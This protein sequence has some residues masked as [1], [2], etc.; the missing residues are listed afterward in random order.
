MAGIKSHPN[1]RT[2]HLSLWAASVIVAATSAASATVCAV[3]RG[4][5]RMGG[6]LRNATDRRGRWVRLAIGRLRAVLVLRLAAI[7]RLLLIVLG[8]VVGVVVVGG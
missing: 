6:P 7:R 5:L 1:R 3:G 8:G 4:G 2:H